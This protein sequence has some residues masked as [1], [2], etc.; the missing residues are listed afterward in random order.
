VIEAIVECGRTWRKRRRARRHPAVMS[1][2][3]LQ[4]IGIGRREMI[5]EI[6]KRFWP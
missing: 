4:D 3:E 2:R 5:H 6:S 1:E